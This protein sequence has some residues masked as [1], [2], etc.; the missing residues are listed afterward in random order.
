[1]TWP[2]WPA[3]LSRLGSPECG[4]DT[5]ILEG[6]LHPALVLAR[7]LATLDQA[8]GGPVIAGLGSG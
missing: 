3:R 1:V 6:L 4:L 2:R 8:S 5:N 7:A